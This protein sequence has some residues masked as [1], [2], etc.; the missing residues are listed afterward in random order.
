ME[1]AATVAVVF[2]AILATVL[3]TKYSLSIQQWSMLRC[4]GPHGSGSDHKQYLAK[5]FLVLGTGTVFC[6]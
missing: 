6:Q 3:S 1:T 4:Y 2:N 5:I